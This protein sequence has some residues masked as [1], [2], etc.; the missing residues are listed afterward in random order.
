MLLGVFSCH[1]WFGPDVF[2]HLA[3]GRDL[4]NSF[5][6]VPRHATLIAQPIPANPYWLFQGLLYLGYAHAGMMVTS[7]LFAVTWALTARAW[8][9]STRL[10]AVPTW[11][12]WLATGAL[13]AVQTRF[14]QR[15]EVFSYLALAWVIARVG[16]LDFTR[17]LPRAGLARLLLVQIAWTNVHGFF[18][19]G[20]LV[21]ATRMVSALVTDARARSGGAIGRGLGVLALMTGATLITPFGFNTWRA[22]AGYAGFR[23][24][25]NDLIQELAPP[26]FS[27][28]VPPLAAFWISL[29]LT[30]ALVVR[31]V[32]KRRDLYAVILALAGGYLAL[33]AVRNLPLFFVMTG[34]L[35]AQLAE[36]APM[37]KA[38]GRKV[39]LTLNAVACVGLMIAF[40]TGDYQNA[41]GQ[42]STF[43]VRLEPASYPRAAARYLNERG[44]AGRVF[45][46]SYDG[47]YLEFELPAATITGDS[48]FADVDRT[49]EFL[50]AI[51]DPA[52]LA[53]LD[54]RFNYD[55]LLINVE[56]LAVFEAVSAS[57]AFGLA[58]VDSHRALFR[59]GAT[60]AAVGHYYAGEDLRH[61]ANAFGPASWIAIAR[62]HRDAGQLSQIL[63]ELGAAPHV[64]AALIGSALG[65]ATGE[66]RCRILTAAAALRPRAF[67]DR[68]LDLVRLDQIIRAAGA[69]PP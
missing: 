20:P 37:R 28:T 33:S 48:Y 35:W 1:S 25:L 12:P 68:E 27:L 57:P 44:F 55:A 36:W 65:F 49:R 8:W 14:E 18:A 64:P 6:F 46:D 56:N 43:G 2:Y 21:L 32:I 5:S 23:G 15:P 29:G 58:H 7:G 24:R 51:R 26:S 60:G 41:T 16:P 40:V 17:P 11:G 4:I 39:S 54:A 66:H 3:W 10:G 9:R 31:A 67:A 13:L 63:T 53:R 47:G 34:P 52:Q 69:C 45:N 38:R 22:V 19:L 62:R 30:A 59:R 42:L 50:G 61:W